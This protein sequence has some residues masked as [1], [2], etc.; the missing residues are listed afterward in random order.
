MGCTNKEGKNLRFLKFKHFYN[1]KRRIYIIHTHELILVTPILVPPKMD[2]TWTGEIVIQTKNPTM[3][4]QCMMVHTV[5][6]IYFTFR[7]NPFLYMQKQ[8]HNL[9]V[10]LI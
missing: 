9:C 8:K 5:L 6:T 7:I 3:K 10:L 4:I 1:Y 2:V